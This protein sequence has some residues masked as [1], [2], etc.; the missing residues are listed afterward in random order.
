MTLASST[1]FTD[2][3]PAVEPKDFAFVYNTVP[4]P[5]RG[6]FHLIYIRKNKNLS[7]DA[8]ERTFGHAWSHDLT[9]WRVDT[10]AFAVQAVWDS[11]HV[12]APSVVQNGNKY[13]M[14]YTGVGSDHNQ[15]T[16]YATTIQL[17]TTNTMWARESTWVFSADST[18]WA[19][20]VGHLVAGQQQFRDPFVFPHPN[21]DS[22]GVFFMLYT[23][24]DTRF[25]PNGFNTVGLAR[26]RLGTLARWLDLAYYRRTD[27]DHFFDGDVESPH[28]F[29]DSGTTSGWRIMLTSGNGSESQS[30]DFTKATAGTGVTDTAL[31]HW[32]GRVHLF[33]YLGGDSTVYGWRGTEHLKAGTVD[34]LAGYDGVGIAIARM[35][36]NGSN[37][38]LKQPS[39]VAVGEGDQGTAEV[40]LL[41]TELQLG[42]PRVGLRIDLPRAMPVRLSVYDVMGR[43]VRTLAAGRLPEGVSA[44]T[45]DCRDAHGGRVG[46]G[47]YFARLAWSAG[48]R[49]VRMPVIR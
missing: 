19:D 37:F 41:V 43:R 40:R 11:R 24:E 23:A 46:S 28:V 39:L 33:A 8:T 22:A 34:F 27:I 20:P 45:W 26:N 36:W 9:A 31:V 12:W 17:D 5:W 38:T 30:I 2:P 1:L 6:M 49:V 13:Y 4:N 44:V 18:S 7:G 15:R 14:F 29:P 16:G 25:I 21:A 48:D 35:Y 32:G 10:A 47:V 3:N 42:A